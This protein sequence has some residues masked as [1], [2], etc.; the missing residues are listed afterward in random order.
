MISGRLD[1][2][3]ARRVAAV[4]VVAA[5]AGVGLTACSGLSSE[6]TGTS[7]ATPAPTSTPAK[8]AKSPKGVAGQVTAETGSTWTVKAKNGKQFTVTIT[9]NTQFGTKKQPSTAQQFPVGSEVR[10]TG[11]VSGTTVQAARVVVPKTPPA[12][13]SAPAPT[14]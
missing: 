9:P 3:M 10:V 12:S 13:P 7:S 14:N 11:T 6:A 8:T 5:A 2:R 4:T 1:R